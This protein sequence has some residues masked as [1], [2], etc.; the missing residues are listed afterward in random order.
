[1]YDIG[2]GREDGVAPA[3]CEL[4]SIRRPGI[5]GDEKNT[6]NLVGA[7]AERWGFWLFGLAGIC[8]FMYR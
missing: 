5:V 8:M 6:L 2:G 3:F 4:A 1:M 7:F